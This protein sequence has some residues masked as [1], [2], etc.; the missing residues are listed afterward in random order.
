MKKALIFLLVAAVL[1]AAGFWFK[2][3]HAAAAEE[4]AAKPAAKVETVAL[5]DQPIA[6]TIEVFGSIVASPAG[7][8]V[9]AAPY[10]C[11][12]R[13]V[14]VSVGATVAA[15]DVLLEVDP[16]PDAKLAADSARSL[17]ALAEAALAA[18]Q[19]R[20]D[21]RLANSQDLLTAKQAAEDAR[22]KA[23]SLAARGLGGDGRIIAAA[24]GVVTKLELAT[25]TLVPTGTALVTVSTGGQLEARLGVEAADVAAVAA[26]QAVSLESSNRPEAEKV[27]ATLRSIGASLD[28]A[29]GAA[30]ARAT[31]PAGSPLLFGEH[32]RAQIELEKKD[33]ALVV[34]R[35]A[36][37]PD[38]DKQVIYTVRAGKAVR[39]EV[40]LGITTDELQEVTGEGLKAGDLVVTLG[41]YELE[42]G[43]AIQAPEKEEKKTD[44]KEPAK[45]AQEAKP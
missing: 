35:S 4:E 38:D 6:R 5:A 29:T 10:D 24:A 39:H 44:A 42:D 16:S 28:P 13:K 20:Y 37:L 30:E 11:L 33:H 21:L 3:R 9:V 27:A 19:Q 1:I 31:V 34:P 14:N 8:R 23:D 26:G 2:S 17:Q 45:P 36:V 12:V 15:G 18:V 32:V 41:N 7:D 25:G 22:L 43:M 40:K